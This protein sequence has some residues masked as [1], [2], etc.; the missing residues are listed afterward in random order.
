MTKQEEKECPI[1]G[2]RFTPINKDQEFCCI[3]CQEEYEM[4]LDEDFLLQSPNFINLG[5]F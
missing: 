5:L 4:S 3:E 1:C 2:R